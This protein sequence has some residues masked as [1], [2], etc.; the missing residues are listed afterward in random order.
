MTKFFNAKR[1]KI[2]TNH[3]FFCFCW[4]V[5]ESVL[6]FLLKSSRGLI[7]GSADT[8]FFRFSVVEVF[9]FLAAFFHFLYVFVALFSAILVFFLKQNLTV[10]I[11]TFWSLD[12]NFVNFLPFQHFFWSSHC[13]FHEEKK[14]PP[15]PKFLQVLSTRSGGSSQRI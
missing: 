2:Q 5:L 6:C 8:F 7:R 14:I 11:I 15:E 10:K 1:G 9:G 3:L 12:Q 13:L 4:A